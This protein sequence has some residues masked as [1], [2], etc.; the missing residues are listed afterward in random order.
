MGEHYGAK[1][2][3][4]CALNIFCYTLG[5]ALTA[6][7][8]LNNVARVAALRAAAARHRNAGLSAALAG[9]DYAGNHWLPSFA[10]YLL[11]DR[12]RLEP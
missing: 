4:S 8:P 6:Q 2:A 3:E 9:R 11:T 10:V 1:H 12:A 7:E 5:S